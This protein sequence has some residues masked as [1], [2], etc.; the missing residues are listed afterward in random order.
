MNRQSTLKFER[1]DHCDTKRYGAVIN[2]VV[3]FVDDEGVIH[4]KIIPKRVP[5]PLAVAYDFN[6]FTHVNKGHD[7]SWYALR[8]N[9]YHWT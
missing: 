3:E 2:R 4:Q 6:V 7:R 8:S 5:G 9:D 1:M